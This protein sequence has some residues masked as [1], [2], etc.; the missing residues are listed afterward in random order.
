VQARAIA[1]L[2]RVIVPLSVLA[3]IGI[4]EALAIYHLV[5]SPESTIMAVGSFL[6]RASIWFILCVSFAENIVVLNVYFPGSMVI[7]F[8]MAATT[9]VPTRAVQVFAAI[10]LGSVLAQHCNFFL[11]RRFSTEEG[12]TSLAKVVALGS[13]SFW[14]PQTGSLASFQIGAAGATYAKYATVLLITWLPWNAFWGVLMYSLGFVPLTGTEF[15]RI[16]VAYLLIWILVE[17]VRG[18]KVSV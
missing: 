3:V 15:M 18:A 5:P 6:G 13:V 14:H 7:L 11:G 16:M 9:G 17:L 1:R 10:V 2:R 4:I 8:S 12:K